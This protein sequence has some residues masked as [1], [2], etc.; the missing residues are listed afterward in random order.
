MAGFSETAAYFDLRA[1]KAR[2]G[3]DQQRF[4]ETAGFYRALAR[5]TPALPLGYKPPQSKPN[6]SPRADRWR[7]RADECR[8]IAQG[9]RDESCRAMLARLAETYEGMANGCSR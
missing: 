3:Q 4:L 1:K 2:D 5:I 9:M 6:G 7:A 8:A